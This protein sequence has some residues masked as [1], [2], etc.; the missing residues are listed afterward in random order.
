MSLLSCASG[1]SIWRGY[2]HF[3]QKKV[4]D[5]EVKSDTQ[6]MAAVDGS[7]RNRYGVMID[8]AH[9]RKSM[10]T[11]PHADGKRIICKHMVAVFFTVFPGEAQKFYDEAM[12]YQEEEERRQDELEDKLI[13]YVSKMKKAE[14]QQKL[15]AL[16]FDGPEWQFER[17]LE[18][19]WI[20]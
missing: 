20:E 14:L 5:L 15:L 17:F 2:D 7:G 3:E 16:L 10:C 19:N 12:A 8:I 1:A 18:E 13:K 4:H 11:C 6:Y 9:P